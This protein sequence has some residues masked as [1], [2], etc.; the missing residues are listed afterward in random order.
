MA[1]QL[2]AGDIQT[3]KTWSPTPQ[4][5]LEWKERKRDKDKFGY[6][7]TEYQSGYGSVHLRQKWSR[8]LEVFL[9][10]KPALSKV[11]IAWGLDY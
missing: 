3:K 10:G 5:T 6:S 9:N 1:D 11:A 4:T 7:K 8:I 2:D